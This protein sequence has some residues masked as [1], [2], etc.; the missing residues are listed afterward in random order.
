MRHLHPLSLALQAAL[1]VPAYAADIDAQ[2]A[3]GDAFKVSSQSG[4]VVRLACARESRHRHPGVGDGRFL[5]RQVG[6]VTPVRH[7]SAADRRAV[8][9][10]EWP[11]RRCLRAQ[12]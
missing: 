9:H 4:G 7:D 11:I 5:E 12:P 10:T 6:N 2:L 8:V 3:N 1:V